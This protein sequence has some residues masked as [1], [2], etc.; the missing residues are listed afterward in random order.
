MFCQ[1][2]T[3]LIATGILIL[4]A[5]IIVVIIEAT[6]GSQGLELSIFGD[7]LG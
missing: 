1:T 5:T 7:L 2:K 3:I 4:L 6:T